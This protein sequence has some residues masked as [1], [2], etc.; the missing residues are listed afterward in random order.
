VRKRR[1]LATAPRTQRKIRCG[2][3]GFARERKYLATAPRTQRKNVAVFSALRE[4]ESVS[5]EHHERKEKF[6]AAFARKKMS[7]Y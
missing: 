6:V 5:P 7:F 3:C 1:V 2:L 4:K